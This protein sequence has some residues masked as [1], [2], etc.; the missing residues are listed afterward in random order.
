MDSDYISFKDAINKKKL[1]VST[2]LKF[3]SKRSELFAELYSYYERSYKK[4]TWSEYI[5]WLKKN[6]YKHSKERVE[7]YKKIKRPIITVRSFC[8]YWFSFIP[9]NDLPYILSIARDMEHR[10]QNFNKW[11]FWSIKNE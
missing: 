6:K 2:P 7:E 10:N 3:N 1:E 5:K 11:L 9:T 4:N 8:S